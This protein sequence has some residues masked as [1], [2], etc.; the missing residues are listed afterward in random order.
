MGGRIM[1]KCSNGKK[2]IFKRL[3]TLLCLTALASGG[4]YAYTKFIKQ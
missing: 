2:S 1:K 3:G 4:Y